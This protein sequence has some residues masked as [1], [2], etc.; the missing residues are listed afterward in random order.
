ME[1][2]VMVAV[3]VT[4]MVILVM[5]VAVMVVVVLVV[6]VV[7]LPMAV[8][9]WTMGLAPMDRTAVRVDLARVAG[10]VRM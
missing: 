9:M 4:V 5:L 10:R 8:G 7:Q 2:V 3:M 6:V 1:A